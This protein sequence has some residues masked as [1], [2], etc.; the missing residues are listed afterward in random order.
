LSANSNEILTFCSE[1][2]VYEPDFFEALFQDNFSDLV[3]LIIVNDNVKRMISDYRPISVNTYGVLIYWEMLYLELISLDDVSLVELTLLVNDSFTRNISPSLL[4][5][6]FI[7]VFLSQTLSSVQDLIIA[8]DASHLAT[9]NSIILN[10]YDFNFFIIENKVNMVKLYLA[11]TRVDPRT[12]DNESIRWAARYGQVK[13]VKLLLDDSRVDPSAKYNEA[14]CYAASSGYFETVRLLLSD[15]RVDPSTNDNC[16]IIIAA[17]N[18]HVET[19]RLLLSDARVDPSTND[20]CA[21]RMAS[22]Y[23]HVEVVKLLLDDT[24][25]Y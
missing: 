7:I 4:N 12:N 17:S 19:V 2:K 23:G 6:P 5:Y 11:E 10:E 13:I 14:I 9:Y 25:V 22:K 21:I 16:A 1:N 8:Y 18:G 20:N 3:D 15:A 24:R